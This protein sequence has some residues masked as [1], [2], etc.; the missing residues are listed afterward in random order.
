VTFRDLIAWQKGMDLVVE[1]YKL[2]EQLPEYEKF[3]LIQ[4]LRRAAVSIPSNIAEGYARTTK[5][6]FA[7]FIDIAM[8]S[9]RE[10]QTQ[11]EI[12]E[13]LQYLEATSERNSAEQVAKI[14]YSLGK[15][16]RL[17]KEAEV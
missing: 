15:S 8:G 13:R 2:T 12:C 7:R 1:I 5:T 16:V 17:N 9:T 6:E 3:G 10:I 4:Q 11:L 14:L